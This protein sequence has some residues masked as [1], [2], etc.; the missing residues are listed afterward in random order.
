MSSDENFSSRPATKRVRS[1]QDHSKGDTK[2]RESD[3]QNEDGKEDGEKDDDWLAQP[4]F[5]VG[6]SKEGWTTKWRESCW[7]GKS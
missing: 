1:D 7:C 4:P 5:S 3:I 2:A 6:K